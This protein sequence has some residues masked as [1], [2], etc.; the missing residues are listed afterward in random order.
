MST[1]NSQYLVHSNGIYHGLPV[2]PDMLQGLTAIVTGANGISGTYMI[3]ALCENPKRWTK[4]YALSRREPWHQYPPQVEHVSMDLLQSPSAI[5]QQ[6]L[7]KKIKADHV[8]FF[9]YIQPSPVAGGTIWS[10]ADEMVR[11]NKSLLGNFL[12][13]L[14]GAAAIPQRISLQLGSKYYGLHLGPAAV[15]QEESAPRVGIEANFY[16]EQEELLGDFCNKYSCQFVTTRPSYLL[17]AVPDAAMN[18]VYPLMVYAVVQK[19]LGKPLI[20]PGD[21]ACW[22]NVFSFSSSMMNAYFTEWLALTDVESGDSFNSI[23]GSPFTWSM[24]WPKYAAYFKMPWEG[25]EHCTDEDYMEMSLPY[26]P[27][28]RGWGPP[29]KRR[30]RYTMVAWAQRS[31]VQTAWREIAAEHGLRNPNLSE[32]NRTFGFADAAVLTAWPC[33]STN[34]KIR[35]NGFFGSVDSTQSILKIFDEYVEI[36]MAPKV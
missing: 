22:E 8:F 7:E 26:A 29:G 12:Q 24:F 28:P 25:P 2:F 13:G 6:L 1:Q 27:P 19:H 30:F 21:L 3:R 16:Y 17:G 35:E 23:D 32:I 15:P 31:V 10:A 33:V 9:A 14:A 18:L 36:K 4:I 11:V 5:A 34:T 20:F